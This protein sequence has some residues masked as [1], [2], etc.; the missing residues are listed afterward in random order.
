MAMDYFFHAR[1]K[2]GQKKPRDCGALIMVLKQIG[3]YFTKLI[4]TLLFC[5]LPLEVL[6][7]A[8]GLS[9]P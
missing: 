2:Q 6:L 3:N 9:S 8:I 1:L 7:V 5:A 4:S